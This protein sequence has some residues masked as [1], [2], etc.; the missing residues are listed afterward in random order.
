MNNTNQNSKSEDLKSIF[1]EGVLDSLNIGTDLEQN[2]FIVKGNAQHI[3]K[4]KNFIK[5]IDKSVPLILIEVM[6]IEVNNSSSVSAGIDIGVGDAPVKS[7]GSIFQ[8]T[9]L[10]ISAARINKIIGG[11]TIGSLN[12]GNVSP[13]FYA[14]IQLLYDKINQ[15]TNFDKLSFAN[16]FFV[17]SYPQ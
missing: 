16:W 12:I 7:Q 13:N 6:I 17:V 10:T 9:D 5:K 11:L 8:G 14:K 3:K 2:S 1:P 4:F 15:N